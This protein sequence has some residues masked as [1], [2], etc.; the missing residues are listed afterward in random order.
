MASNIL[1]RISAVTNP[2]QSVGRQV[3]CISKVSVN[4]SDAT[5]DLIKPSA[6]IRFASAQSQATNQFTAAERDKIYTGVSYG[7]EAQLLQAQTNKR[8]DKSAT[9]YDEPPTED[10][11]EYETG[12]LCKYPGQLRS[13]S[14]LQSLTNQQN[15]V[16]SSTVSASDDQRRSKSGRRGIRALHTKPDPKVQSA[17][18]AARQAKGD[19][20]LVRGKTLGMKL[21]E[22]DVGS[23]NDDPRLARTYVR[24][25]EGVYYCVTGKAELNLEGQTTVI[26]ADQSW[27]VPAN[28]K[29]TYKIIEGPFKAVEAS[30]L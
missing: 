12:E 4:L 27:T 19:K 29:H 3:R 25:Q 2:V 22:A 5:Y 21:W 11:A 8:S 7:N 14:E 26:K 15:R 1:K 28:A 24:Q 10:V 17:G 6:Y 9:H 30:L 13:E 23:S 18:S 16:V 20:E